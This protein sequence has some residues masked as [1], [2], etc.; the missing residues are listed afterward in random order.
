MGTARSLLTLMLKSDQKL[1]TL[2]ICRLRLFIQYC[3]VLLTT[4]YI[5]KYL[6]KYLNLTLLSDKNSFSY[7]KIGNFLKFV[8]CYFDYMK[9]LLSVEPTC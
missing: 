8:L 5:I 7:R 4:A 9:R 1:Q 3:R 6:I 2:D